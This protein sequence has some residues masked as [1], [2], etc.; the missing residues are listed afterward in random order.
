MS[1][2]AETIRRLAE[3]IASDACKRD[4]KHCRL[5]NLKCMYIDCSADEIIEDLKDAAETALR[6]KLSEHDTCANF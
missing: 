6:E 4:P 2:H 1:T 3:A 5:K